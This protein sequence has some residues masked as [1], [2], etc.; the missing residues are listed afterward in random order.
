M[1][2]GLGD[3]CFLCCCCCVFVSLCRCVF[4]CLCRC[5]VV[6]LCRCVVAC[7]RVFVWVWVFGGEEQGSRI[8]ALCALCGRGVHNTVPA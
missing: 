4:V 6:S 1:H 3:C 8:K 2:A 7:L 5:V